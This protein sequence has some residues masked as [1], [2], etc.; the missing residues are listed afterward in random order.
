MP[1]LLKVRKRPTARKPG[2]LP[3]ALAFGGSLLCL[4]AGVVAA[5][6][7]FQELALW[8]LIA[9]FA[10]EAIGFGVIPLLGRRRV[11]RRP[12]ER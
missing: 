5:V 1:K 4:A 11:R 3:G 6:A 10:I 12:E 2:D 8:L 9:A 7:G